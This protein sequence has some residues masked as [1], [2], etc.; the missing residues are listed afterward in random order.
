[1][2][3]NATDYINDSELHQLSRLTDIAAY[4]GFSDDT[5]RRSLKK[6]DSSFYHKDDKGAIVI[7]DL[8]ELL[9]VLDGT[10]IRKKQTQESQPSSQFTGEV[11]E[12]EIIH[13]EPLQPRFTYEDTQLTY[14]PKQHVTVDYSHLSGQVSNIYD[15]AVQLR[16][17]L[18]LAH[19]G[20]VQNAIAQSETA[21]RLEELKELLAIQKREQ[22]AIEA[23]RIEQDEINRLQREEEIRLKT[24]IN[25]EINQGKL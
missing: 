17:D 22:A 12:P 1:M 13:T 6:L 16:D 20:I 3:F 18:T 11:I 14:E 10:Q 5:L 2:K 9:A 21:K 7:D 4:L 25:Y 8:S 19:N 24:Q 23:K 15:I